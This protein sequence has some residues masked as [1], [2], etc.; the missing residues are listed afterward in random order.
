MQPRVAV[1]TGASSGI[2]RA[3]AIRF[4]QAGWRVGLI[5][6]SED[7]LEAVCKDVVEHGG[8]AAMAIAD[9]ADSG[10]LE[11][12]AASIE[13]VLG[14]LDVWVNNAGVGVWG[15]F[16][17]IPEDEF[18]RVTEV[19][20]FGIVNGSRIA[21]KRMAASGYGTIVQ[22]LSV[23]SYRGVP[24][25]T[26]YSGAKYA[27]RGFTDALRSELAAKGSRVHVTMVHPP[28]VNTPFYD[29]AGSHMGRKVRPPPPVYQPELIADAIYAAATMRRREL[30]VGGQTLAISL[31]NMVAPGLMDV[32]AGKLG[33][34][35]QLRGEDEGP[36]ESGNLHAPSRTH[37]VHGAFD[38]ESLS[39][40]AQGWM[41]RNR[42]AVGLGLGL[43]ALA[44]LAGA[45]RG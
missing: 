13:A 24:L 39:H 8:T 45:R 44:W 6:R 36:P 40:S 18:R 19:N 17:D 29:H 22:V 3:T 30:K 9:V 1:I 20:Y 16:E 4:A 15:W 25:Q 7:G 32:L 28:A 41:N 10:Q 12:A 31:G 37:A 34:S 5:A 11:A 38:A 2:G 27:A 43:I 35:P 14:P 42:D 26:P 23:I 21:L 33:V